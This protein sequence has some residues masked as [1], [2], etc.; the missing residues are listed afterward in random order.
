M[1]SHLRKHGYI[2]VAYIDD[3]LLIGHMFRECADNIQATV[4]LL[5]SLGFTVHLVKSVL[6]P[7][8]VIVFLGFEINSVT[9]TV[10]LTHE[11]G[12]RVKQACIKL[13]Q[14][15]DTTTIRQLAEVIG[16]LVASAPAV[17]HAPLFYR[18]LEFEKD[19]ALKTH[20]GNYDSKMTLSKNAKHELQWWI[21]NIEQSVKPI[22]VPAPHI[23][24]QSDSSDYGWGGVSKNTKTGGNWSEQ[25]AAEHINFKELKA[26]F[27]TLQTF[28]DNCRDCHIRMEID[29]T[30]AVAY[31]NNMGGK[32]QHLN[33]L[34]RTIW[35][36]AKERHLWLSASYL[37][38]SLNILADMESR[39]IRDDDKEWMLNKHIFNKISSNFGPFDIDLFAS[40][41]N[42]QMMPY[43]AWLP[44]P[45]AMAVNAFDLSW[46]N[47]YCYAFPPFSILTQVLQKVE[48]DEAEMVLVAPM[49]TTQPWFF[50]LLRLVVDHPRILPRGK[51]TLILPHN[52]LRVHPLY[53]KMH[54][55]AYRLSGKAS[56]SEE[57]R[58]GLLTSSCT[59][60]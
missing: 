50:T 31:I 40:R 43:V 45:H 53:Q 42:Y 26:A 48:Q 49:W 51:Q 20:Y 4:K 18:G 52:Q 55:A 10:S 57:F 60:G 37:K 16:L 59:P 35:L 32:K 2:N 39:K 9:M 46:E 6:T 27:L 56:S 38:G 17:P 11:K 3:S 15:K 8:Q 36:W 44:D 14:R 25:E 21:D 47:Y 24:L 22:Q 19:Q 28:C 23:T 29:N 33:L 54:L 1:F 7:T 58:K 30:T 5:D 34:A 13:V 12:Q 41:L